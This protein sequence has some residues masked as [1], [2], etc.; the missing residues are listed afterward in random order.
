MSTKYLL[1]TWMDRYEST[2]VV[3]GPSLI[4]DMKVIDKK[5]ESTMTG[6]NRGQSCNLQESEYLREC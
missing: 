2:N 5:F 6:C 4:L 1:E 3:K